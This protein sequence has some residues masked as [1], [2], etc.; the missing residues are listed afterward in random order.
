M[1]LYQLPPV[2]TELD[3]TWFG[4]DRLPLDLSL[5][6]PTLIKLYLN[7]FNISGSYVNSYLTHLML[8]SCE[9]AHPDI[10]LSLNTPSVTHLSLINTRVNYIVP[11]ELTS[12]C[13]SGMIV[14]REF[15]KR[16]TVTTLILTH[17]NL[18][19]AIIPYIPGT[20][21]SLDVSF[22]PIRDVS[23]LSGL[24]CLNLRNTLIDNAMLRLIARLSLKE[25]NVE[26]TNVT[27]L[28]VLKDTSIEVLYVSEVHASEMIHLRNL[29][30]T[31][32]NGQVHGWSKH[33]PPCARYTWDRY[34]LG[35]SM[36]NRS[37]HLT[38]KADVYD[39]IMVG[40]CL[41][42]I[43]YVP[44]ANS[45]YRGIGI[46]GII[47]GLGLMRYRYTLTLAPDDGVTMQPYIYLG[48][49]HRNHGISFGFGVSITIVY[50]NMWNYL[51][52]V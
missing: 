19:D 12:L 5:I 4:P 48:S 22:N 2:L 8:N 44:Y 45:I 40:W 26:G 35:L 10:L 20:V 36:T 41:G 31:H 6:S 11:W 51:R 50:Y 21:K 29:P 15:I 9:A 23:S 33:M 3:L 24:T 13:L 17:C 49:L 37:R 38:V 28:E 52:R 34:L 1:T 27:Q 7:D 46:G 47:M 14:D 30:L 39:G 25:L 18:D 32:F 42:V 16:L 43:S